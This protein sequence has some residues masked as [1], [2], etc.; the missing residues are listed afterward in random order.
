MFTLEKAIKLACEK[1]EGQFRWNGDP[2]VMHLL[3]V[4]LKMTTNDE[5]IVAVLH[6]SLEDTNLTE[7]DL[8]EAGCPDHLIAAIVLLTHKKED[9]YGK[10]VR[11][12]NQ[13]VIAKTVKM[14]DI[15]DNLDLR[16]IG[17]QIT[18]RDIE[19]VTKYVKALDFLRNEE[20]R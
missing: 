20:T 4:M 7:W 16:N 5:R 8:F 12:L 14:E 6:D 10:Y 3:R 15:S 17:H 9:S 13:N 11:K 19:R 2:Y 1:H 18:E